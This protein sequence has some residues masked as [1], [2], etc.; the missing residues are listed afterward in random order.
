MKK[1]V[2]AAASLMMAASMIG[3]VVP[4]ATG[5]ADAT[6]TLSVLSYE[7]KQSSVKIDTTSADVHVPVGIYLSEGTADAKTIMA[8]LTINS[9]GGDASSAYVNFE[10]LAPNN[11]L[12]AERDVTIGDKTYKSDKI[13]GFNS[14]V[15]EGRKGLNSYL[16]GNLGGESV[17]NEGMADAGT[18]NPYVGLAW[19][20]P[21][22]GYAWC[23]AKSDD[24]PFYVVDITFKKGT[25]SGTYTVDFLDYVYDKDHP[26]NKAT[27]IEI[28]GTKYTT[29]NKNLKLNSF[30]VTVGDAAPEDT[31]VTTTA[32]TTKKDDTTTTTTTKKDDTTTPSVEAAVTPE[33]KGEKSSTFKINMGTYEMTLDELKA[34]GY[35][36]EVD[37]YAECSESDLSGML[38]AKLGKLPEQVKK[39]EM[40]P[41]CYAGVKDAEWKDV[42]E[43][44][45]NANVLNGGAPVVLSPDGEVCIYDVTLDETKVKAGDTIVINFA[46]FDVQP[47]G[48]SAMVA[49]LVTPAV[50]KIKDDGTSTTATTATTASTTKSTTASTATTTVASGD[51]LYG[52]ANDDKKVNIADVVVLNKWLANNESITINKK[53]ADCFNPKDGAEINAQ[54]SDAIIRSIVHLVTLPAQG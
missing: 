25:P 9:K 33:A 23:G 6:K 40:D 30:T 11:T 2:S 46:R 28:A 27:M 44:T 3:S 17:D 7:D 4:F 48:K 26:E 39:I 10:G 20:A 18:K 49:P 22:D 42:G 32:T 51:V 19:T 15:T 53:N 43:N 45:Y 35:K 12:G 34:A 54:D 13:I 1:L 52:D 47:D 36:V 21:T 5:A 41:G 50:I 38:I 14:V 31:T 16:N 37:V 8:K 29:D 24:F